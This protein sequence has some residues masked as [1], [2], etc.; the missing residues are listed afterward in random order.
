MKFH[1]YLPGALLSFATILMLLS[2]TNGAY[3]TAGVVVSASCR[4]AIWHGDGSSPDPIQ[5]EYCPD[6]V[7]FPIANNTIYN[8]A[9]VGWQAPNDIYSIMAKAYHNARG[10]HGNLG[11]AASTEAAIPASSLNWY[12]NLAQSSATVTA[13]DTILVTNPL[14]E[15]G[16]YVTINLAG[17]VE[18][19]LSGA[20][21]N[22]GEDRNAANTSAFIFSSLTIREQYG[23]TAGGTFGFDY[24]FGYQ[25]PCGESTTGSFFQRYSDTMSVRVGSTLSLS[26]YLTASSESYAD[27]RLIGKNLYTLSNA[28]AMNSFTTYLTP[29]TDGVQLLA[30]S[31]H[32]YSAPVPVPAAVWLFGS[33]LLGLIGVARRKAV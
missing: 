31:G 29:V 7:S 25:G 6:Y 4:A 27:N 13:T 17:Y 12:S 26:S 30:E 15:Q 20:V 1:R 21:Y 10:D 14:L 8:F 16:T 11:V 22:S 23:G 18:G 32:D 28:Q 9:I 2:A 33:G 5:G 24:C 19:Y 3:A